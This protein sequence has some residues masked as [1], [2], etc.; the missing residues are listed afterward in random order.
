MSQDLDRRKF[1]KQTAA[2]SKQL[3]QVSFWG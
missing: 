2:A 1:I 3:L